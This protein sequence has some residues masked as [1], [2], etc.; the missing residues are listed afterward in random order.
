MITR[1]RWRK[2]RK[3]QVLPT[4]DE[5]RMFIDR[6]RIALELEPLY[7]EEKSARATPQSRVVSSSEAPKRERIGAISP[8]APT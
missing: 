3:V 7:G 4:S 2:G 6:L 5:Q 8:G 1:T